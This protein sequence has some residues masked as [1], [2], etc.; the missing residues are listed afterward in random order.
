M[1]VFAM[2]SHHQQSYTWHCIE[3]FSVKNNN[4]LNLKISEDKLS[5]S[6]EKKREILSKFYKTL[7]EIYDT[8]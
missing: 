3:E 5:N 8:D 1:M 2:Q 7:A 4:I 6:M